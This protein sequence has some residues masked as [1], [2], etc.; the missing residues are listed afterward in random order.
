MKMSLHASKKYLIA[1]A[2]A[3]L[4]LPMAACDIL[5]DTT[6]SAPH[7][8][9]YQLDAHGC[10]TIDGV[11]PNGNRTM[12]YYQSAEPNKLLGFEMNRLQAVNW[13]STAITPDVV[14]DISYGL[15]DNV[16]QL[17]N[18]NAPA[19]WWRSNPGQADQV[20]Y[21]GAWMSVEDYKQLMN[22]QDETTRYILTPCMR[23]LNGC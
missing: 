17:Y 22:A 23:S 2:A 4:C 1:A 19:V 21:S 6:S 16:Y 8:I 3:L 14:R 11:Y 9:K 13:N 10:L 7:L 18:T 15:T 20:L 5:N 12:C